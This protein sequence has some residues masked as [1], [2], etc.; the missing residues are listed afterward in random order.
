MCTVARGKDSLVQCEAASRVIVEGIMAQEA[1]II[2]DKWH[3][4]ICPER[5]DGEILTIGDTVPL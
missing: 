2:F 5:E 4:N 3:D 1:I